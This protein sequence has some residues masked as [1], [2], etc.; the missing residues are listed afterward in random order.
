MLLRLSIESRVNDVLVMLQ[1]LRKILPIGVPPT[2]RTTKRLGTVP[3]RRRL[4]LASSF[5][6]NLRMILA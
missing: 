2:N 5:K 6:R 1:H 4:G 3:R